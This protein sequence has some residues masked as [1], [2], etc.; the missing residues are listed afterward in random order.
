MGSPALLLSVLAAVCAALRQ[1]CPLKFRL[2]PAGVDSCCYGCPAG[3]FLKNECT[4]LSDSLCETCP[5]GSYSE[6]WNKIYSCF[7]CDECGY[8]MK[9]KRNCTSISNAQ[10]EC[11]EGYVCKDSNCR[12]CMLPGV[13]SIPCSTGTFSTTGTRP[14]QPWTNCTS[15]GQVEIVPANQTSDAF[16]DYIQHTQVRQKS[17]TLEVVM[18]IV[19]FIS[20][21][22]LCL[23]VG[24][25]ITKCRR[26]R[27]MEFE[28]LPDKTQAALPTLA[29]DTI[30]IRY[31]EQECGGPSQPK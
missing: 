3:N 22:L 15:L 30:T 23:S 31:P 27:R 21:F 8:G 18:S 13:E 28:L 19:A 20:L 11:S 9:Y 14:C 25:H 16:C 10:C 7:R 26:Y 2:S 24:A 29:E 1:D 12:S 17:L 4:A 6:Q 5:N